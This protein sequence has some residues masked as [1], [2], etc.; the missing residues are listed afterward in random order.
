MALANAAVFEAPKL[1]LRVG[2]VTIDHRLQEGSAERASQVAK[3]LRGLGCEPVEVVGVHVGQGGGPEAAARTARYAGLD[4]AADRCGAAA[5]LLGHTLDDQAETV[6]LGLARGS[7]ARSLA[8]MTSVSGLYRRP[9]LGVTRETTRAACEAAG[10]DVW[11]DPH[12]E[13]PRFARV[14][15]R[16][17]VLPVL[18]RELG[19]GIAQALARTAALLREDADAL[20][21]LAGQVDDLEVDTLAALPTA[22]RRRVL[23]RAAIAAG[24][25]GG[26]LSAAHLQAIDALITDWHGQGPIHLPGGVAAERRYGTLYFRG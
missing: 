3:A 17:D 26:R 23:K 18:E 20:D 12:N 24:V 2:G 16:H 9:L 8:G 6:L 15:V 4:A 10:L 5:V 7:G 19:P 25:P 11:A 21:A 22:I 14:R 13:D 1:G